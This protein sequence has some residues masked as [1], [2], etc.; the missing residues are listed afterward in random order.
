V[1]I[2]SGDE[3]AL[4]DALAAFGP[5]SI[6]IHVTP[7]FMLYKDGI[8]ED[9]FCLNGTE[10]LNHA[11]LGVGYDSIE[12]TGEEFWILKNSW[13]EGWGERGYMRLA[14]NKNNMCGVATEAS[15]ASIKPR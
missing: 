7:K 2:K 15:Y 1:E 3:A 4:R 8:F 9:E 6:D 12:R 13:S 10:N 14:R 5:V 11:V